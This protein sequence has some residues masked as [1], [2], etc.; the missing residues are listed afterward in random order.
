MACYVSQDPEPGTHDLL[1]L[2]VRR[3]RRVLIPWM[4]DGRGPLQIAWG[5]YTDRESLVAGP[6]GI[7]QPA[8]SLGAEGL[9]EASLILCPA[10]AATPMGVRLGTGGGWYDRALLHASDRAKSACLV[11]DDEI[12]STLPTDP[13]DVRMDL[14]A[15]QT[16]LRGW[17]DA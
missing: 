9:A 1:D 17:R 7:L 5:E 8:V 4:G 6:R 10:L 11:D 13:W 2:L 12:F 16:R 3:G 14:I 15:T